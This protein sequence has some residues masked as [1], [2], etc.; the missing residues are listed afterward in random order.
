M[1]AYSLSKLDKLGE[2]SF[3]LLITGGIIIPFFRP[4]GGTCGFGI[5][6]KSLFFTDTYSKLD[7]D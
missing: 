1:K 3:F 6:T 2:I 5:F 4:Y 7:G